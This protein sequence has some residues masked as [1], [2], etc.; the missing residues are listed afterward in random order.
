MPELETMR[1]KMKDS[2]SVEVN[3]NVEDFDP[4]KHARM[5]EPESK[6]PEPPPSPSHPP[7]STPSSPMPTPSS[8]PTEGT[9]GEGEP[10][11]PGRRRP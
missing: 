8:P 10:S 2:P 3:I 9:S 11:S 4:E 7:P 5:D 1:V 6:P